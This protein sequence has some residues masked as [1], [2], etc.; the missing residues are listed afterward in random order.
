MSAHRISVEITWRNEDNTEQ[1]WT[2]TCG[3]RMAWTT[4]TYEA[5]EDEWRKHCH[6]VTGI[7]PKPMGGKTGRW[8]P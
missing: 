3:C 4:P 6:E 5:T 7:A 2:G 1:R 8:T